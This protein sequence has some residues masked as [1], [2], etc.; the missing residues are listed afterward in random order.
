MIFKNDKRVK[1]IDETNTDD[2]SCGTDPSIKCLYFD[3]KANMYNVQKCVDAKKK[4]PED[5]FLKTFNLNAQSMR[6]M[7]IMRNLE[8]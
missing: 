7:E 4:N 8:E 3:Y 2:S 6:F 1:V 5:K